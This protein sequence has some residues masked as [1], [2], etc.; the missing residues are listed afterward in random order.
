M[1]GTFAILCRVRTDPDWRDHGS[2]CSEIRDGVT[3]PGSKYFR[4]PRR[5]KDG[6]GNEAFT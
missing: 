5:G 6:C 2:A 3:T 1:V 4:Q